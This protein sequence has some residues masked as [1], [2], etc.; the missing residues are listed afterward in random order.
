MEAE[1]GFAGSLMWPGAFGI[2]LSCVACDES[3]GI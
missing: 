2:T 1:V 3:T